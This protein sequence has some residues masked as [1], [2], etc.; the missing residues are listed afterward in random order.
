M[1]QEIKSEV[2]TE[3]ATEVASEVVSPNSENKRNNEEFLHIKRKRLEEILNSPQNT[4]LRRLL[5]QEEHEQEEK[6]EEIPTEVVNT[7]EGSP[8]KT[9]QRVS[10]L[11]NEDDFVKRYMKFGNSKE[12]A[13]K[14]YRKAIFIYIN[15]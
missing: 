2:A 3:V 11:L 8:F 12:K 9:N 4:R 14:K 10:K 13:Q 6:Q 5:L 15:N 7:P 1:E